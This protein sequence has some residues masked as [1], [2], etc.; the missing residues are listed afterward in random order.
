MSS[1]Q[2]QTDSLCVTDLRNLPQ[3][4]E[5]EMDELNNKYVQFFSSLNS[6]IAFSWEGLFPEG[7]LCSPSGNKPS[8]LK[9]IPEFSDEE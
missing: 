5:K 9:A 1:I 7:D 2:R 8:Q 6:G 4:Q 3:T